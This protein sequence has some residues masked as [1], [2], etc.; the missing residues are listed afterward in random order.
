MQRIVADLEA[1]FAFSLLQPRIKEVLEELKTGRPS[2]PPSTLQFGVSTKVR[3]GWDAYRVQNAEKCTYYFRVR[4]KNLNESRV[5]GTARYYAMLHAGGSAFPL[6]RMT[7]G[8]TGFSLQ[9]GESYQYSFMVT[10][11]QELLTAQGGLLLRSDDDLFEVG[12]ERLVLHDAPTVREADIDAMN[13]GYNF[14]GR[15]NIRIED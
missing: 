14:M 6:S 12:L 8:S 15:L 10:L 13:A 2:S 3:T 4:V 9:P 7:Q 11:A 5:A 1:R